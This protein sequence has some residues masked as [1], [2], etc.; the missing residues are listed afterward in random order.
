ML[1]F[2][3]IL[4]LIVTTY[5][6]YIEKQEKKMKSSM[7]DIN[8]KMS[9]TSVLSSPYAKMMGKIFKLKYSHPLNLP[10]TYYGM[11]FYLAITLYSYFPFILIPYREKILLIVSILSIISSCVLAYILYAKLRTVCIICI[12]TYIINSFILYYSLIENK[13]F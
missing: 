9:C 13:I 7:C 12:S 8:D 11:I 5:A 6:I 1:V 3:G 2:L 4:G 10:N